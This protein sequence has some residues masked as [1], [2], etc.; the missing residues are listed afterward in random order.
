MTYYEDHKEQIKAY[1][2]LYYQN[3]KQKY[4]DYYLTNREK[5]IE[6]AKKNRKTYSAQHLKA[7]KIKRNLKKNQ[8][9]ADK[10]KASIQP[11]NIFG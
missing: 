8:D 1:S 10:F 11:N 6:N 5:M 3:N 7:L 2:K 4:K 9:K